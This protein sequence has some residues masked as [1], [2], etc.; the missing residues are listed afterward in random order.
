M[1]RLCLALFLLACCCVVAAV[2]GSAGS[3][4][5]RVPL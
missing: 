2:V 4:L 5:A 3:L 1:T